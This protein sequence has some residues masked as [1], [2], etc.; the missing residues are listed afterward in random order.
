[1]YIS[2]FIPIK[3]AGYMYGAI[4][5]SGAPGKKIPGDVDHEWAMV[6]VNAVHESIEFGE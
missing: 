5:I 4:G 2:L 3:I 6:G 1:M